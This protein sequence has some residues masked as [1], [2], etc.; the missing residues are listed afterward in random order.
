MK[1]ISKAEKDLLG[2][3]Y[4]VTLMCSGNDTQN[5]TY[6]R[7][8]KE[9]AR[10]I[11]KRKHILVNGASENGL[12]GITGREA[13]EHGGEVYG[14]GLKDYEPVIHPWF[15]NWEGFSS[16]NL[17]IR[18]LTDLGDVFF[19][20]AGGLGTLHEILDLHINQF[21]GNELRP[22]IIMSPMA[23]I[24]QDICEK[25]KEEG[26]YWSKLPENIHYAKTAEEAL[27]ILDKI[28]SHYD[29]EGYINK[30]YY[31][32]LGSEEIYTDIKA[33]N[34]KYE[35]LYAGH[36]WVVHPD[37]YPPNRFRSS[38][39]FA[40]NITKE[41]CRDKV[42]FDIGCGPGNLGILGA[43]AGAQKVICVDINPAAVANTEE[44]VKRFRLENV[45]VREGSVFSAIGQE[46]AD[47]IFFHPPFHHEKIDNNHT[48]LMNCVSTDGFYVLNEFFKKIHMYLKPNG[49]IYLGFSNKDPKSLAHLEILLGK[50]NYEI[51]CHEY[52]N[53]DADYRFYKITM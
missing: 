41:L 12:M 30:T 27:A 29:E 44:N 6:I 42:I 28:T 49:T 21:L 14:I 5:E 33:Y 51:I 9:I 22:I 13:Y 15:S 50:Y 47:V 36:K 17:R 38:V 11:A 18:R 20:L 2:Y 7:D 52:K 10:G 3:K 32:V 8:A 4:R 23:E 31:P 40:K 34:E 46:K 25:V 19:A 16:Y 53:S 24:Y 37:V 43:L 26:L 1:K 35:I 48:K 39:V 45:D